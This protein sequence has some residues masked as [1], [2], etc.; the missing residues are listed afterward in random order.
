MPATS[1]YASNGGK[2]KFNEFQTP[3][4]TAVHSYHDKAQE[5]TDDKTGKPILDDKG[6]PKADFKITLAWDKTRVAT[7]LAE[8][9]ALASKTRDEAWG[10]DCA[11]DQ[12]FRLQPFFR[13]GDNPEHNTK[14]RD[15][16]FGKYYLNFKSKAIPI[17]DAAGNWTKTY[18]GAPGLVDEYA[19]DMLPV[20]FW[21]GCDARVTGI[22]FGSEY[23]GKNFISVRLN[24]IQRAKK[25]ERLGG[26]GRPDAKSQFDALATA[27]AQTGGFGGFGGIL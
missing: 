25:G 18:S 1:L 16:L 22:M 21:A 7:D 11:N 6:I 17:I 20:D 12:W 9:V 4:G 19:N 14:R 23:M 8:M 26:G 5:Q 27:P 2:P 10:A 24:N 3:I 15:Y 13:D